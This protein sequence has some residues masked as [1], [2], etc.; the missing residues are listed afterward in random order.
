MENTMLGITLREVRGLLNDLMD[1]LCGEDGQVWLKALKLFLRKENP[2]STRN[3]EVWKTIKLSTGLKTADDF[4]KALEKGGHVI[5]SWGY[6]ILGQLAFKV[7]ETANYVELVK[8][9]VRELGFKNGATNAQINERA[10][11]LGL[12]LCPNEVGPQ[13]RLQYKDQPKGERI[14]V[15]MEPIVGFGTCPWLFSV[16]RNPDGVS[17]LRRNDG[18]PRTYWEDADVLFV[19][20]R[21]RRA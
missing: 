18:D 9:T 3:W 14:L 10:K 15:A 1:K 5:G 19:F 7:S 11:E 6:G 16:E 17:Y 12:E 20:V 8:I 2:W 21:P 13:L 4:H